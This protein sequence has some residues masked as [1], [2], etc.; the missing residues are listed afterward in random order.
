MKS[1][2]ENLRFLFGLMK[3]FKIR[4]WGYLHNFKYAKNQTYTL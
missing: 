2:P 1:L 3:T 4:L